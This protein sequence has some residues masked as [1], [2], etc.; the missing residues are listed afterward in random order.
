MPFRVL[1]LLNQDFYY[2]QFWSFLEKKY[3]CPR[4]LYFSKMD[5]TLSNKQ[6]QQIADKAAQKTAK[7]VLRH[8]KAGQKTEPLLVSVKEAARILGVSVDHMRKLKDEYPYIRRGD[9]Q[10]GHIFFIRESLMASL[11]TS[12]INNK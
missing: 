5:I 10:Q 1:N 12:N 2:A 9:N 3:L 11:P 8:L 4:I 7:L 6:I